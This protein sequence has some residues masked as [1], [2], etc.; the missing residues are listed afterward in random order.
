MT[1]LATLSACALAKAIR[2]KQLSSV[3]ATKAAIERLQACHELTNCLIALEAD[4]ALS[5]AKAA[6]AA[7]ANA[8][9]TG[10]L[11]GVPL[12]HKDMF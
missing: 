1:D 2:D 12:A 4:E 10:P 3:E 11:A 9:A 8:R 7:I 5:A 6:D